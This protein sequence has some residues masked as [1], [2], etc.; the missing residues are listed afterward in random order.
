ME[1]QYKI[2]FD[3]AE[4]NEYAHFQHNFSTGWY[5]KNR[6]EALKKF[7]DNWTGT[8]QVI[9]TSIYRIGIRQETE[10]KQDFAKVFIPKRNNKKNIPPGKRG[11]PGR[12]QGNKPLPPKFKREKM[13]DCR[14][15]AYIKE[16]LKEQPESMGFLLEEACFLAY[17]SRGLKRL[18]KPK[19]P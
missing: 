3:W 1:K 11:G 6:T 19:K 9:V 12:G 16:W 13:C 4:N 5:A 7:L 17:E 10:K 15:Q 2:E 18:E 8:N 14:M